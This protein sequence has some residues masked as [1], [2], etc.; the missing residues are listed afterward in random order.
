LHPS[1]AENLLS[2]SEGNPFLAL[3]ILGHLATPELSAAAEQL[4][5]TAATVGGDSSRTLLAAASGLPVADFDLALA[6][7]L[8]ARLLK[9]L[10]TP[11][12]E[13]TLERLDLYHDRIREAAY[14]RLAHDRRRAL[15]RALG[16]TLEAQ[17]TP[18]GREPP[19]EELLRHYSEAGD[20]KKQRHFAGK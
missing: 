10:P 1:A 8:S 6:E 14:A 5:A 13:G 9:A 7:L 16:L 19:F 17:P 18:S 4:L 15:H 2:R 12:A 11:A 3:Q 20:R